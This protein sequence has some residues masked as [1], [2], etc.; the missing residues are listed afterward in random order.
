MTRAAIYCRIS[1]DREGKEVGVT[2][3]TR[4]CRALARRERLSVVEV[5]AENDTSASRR[6]RKPRPEYA[7]LLADAKAGRFTVIVALSTSRLTRRFREHEDLIDLATQ[8]GIGYRFVKSPSFD[9]NTADGQMVARIMAAADT[10]EADRIAERVRDN[11][12]ARVRDGEY[13]GGPRGYGVAADGRTL[14]E[15]EAERIRDWYR[16]VLDGGTLR[17]IAVALN[18][19]GVPSMSGA[20]WRAAVVRKILVNPRNA[21][22]R[23][24]AGAQ[25]PASHP[26]IVDAEVWRATAD[27]LTAPGRNANRGAGTATKHLGAGLL[28]CGRCA[29]RTVASGYHARGHLVYRCLTCWRT[30]RAEPLNEFVNALVE[31]LLTAADAA[32]RLLPR[33]PVGGVDTAALHTE[34]KAIRANMAADAAAFFTA[35]RGATAAAVRAGLEAGER[36]L[37]EIDA[38]LVAAGRVSPAAGVLTADDP[39][40]AWRAIGDVARRQAIVR[41]L[42]TITLGAPPRGRVR[43]THDVLAGFI[44]ARPRRAER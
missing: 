10:A 35:A 2:D 38:A 9:L 23:V 13:H 18:R 12:R 29:P 39:V 33:R 17:G 24:V 1:D 16:H 22:L 32:E 14:V 7:R 31:E 37:A 42:M 25:Y 8:H 28:T 26:A 36:R 20:P 15:G 5:Y 6:A 11:V 34:A 43:L 3:Q 4:Q 27:V 19:D 21:G 44:D 40:A 41:A 30:W